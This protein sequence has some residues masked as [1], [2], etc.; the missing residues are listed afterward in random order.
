MQIY[1][2][3][4]VVFLLLPGTITFA[5]TDATKHIKQGGFDRKKQ[6]AIALGAGTSTFKVNNSNWNQGAINYNDSL[7]SI[8]SNAVFKFDLSILYLI[9]FNKY[10][11]FRPAI[12]TSFEGGKVQYNKLQLSE[13]LNLT[14]ASQMVSLPMLIKFP[15]GVIQ[16]YVLIGPSLI[17]ISAQDESAEDLLPLKNFDVLADAALGI[18]IDAQKLKIIM[19]PEVKLS[20]GLLNQKGTANNLYTS[21]IEHLKRQAFTFSL[22]LRNR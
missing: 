1:R 12:T 3:L 15:R 18:D 22:Y 11:A 13:T 7:K 16:P 6:F 10:F 8:I 19:T 17:Y 20:F 9:N 21:T 4:F 2:K 5:Q 14:T